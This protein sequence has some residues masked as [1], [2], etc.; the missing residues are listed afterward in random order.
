MSAHA[1]YW[2][3][4][5]VDG[6]EAMGDEEGEDEDDDQRREE[7]ADVRVVLQIMGTM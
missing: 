5:P 7:V 2:V 1:Q 3:T 4:H 6:H